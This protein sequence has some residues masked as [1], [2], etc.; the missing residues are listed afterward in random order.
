MDHKNI[1]QNVKLSF[2]LHSDTKDGRSCFCILTPS[3]DVSAPSQWLECFNT[4]L[5][6]P[7]SKHQLNVARQDHKKSRSRHLVAIYHLQ[8]HYKIESFSS[9][10]HFCARYCR[11][12]GG[13]ITIR[14]P[15]L[16]AHIISINVI[17]LFRTGIG[18]SPKEGGMDCGS[19][20]CGS[21]NCGLLL[22]D[23]MK[24]CKWL[25]KGWDIQ[26]K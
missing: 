9:R 2:I 22:C 14:F 4:S 5:S 6:A 3:S 19:R 20:C 12:L 25:Q 7:H 1:W 11:I 15:F 23:F 18:L 21:L 24:S 26:Y 10:W 13:D 8:G 16:G 17:A